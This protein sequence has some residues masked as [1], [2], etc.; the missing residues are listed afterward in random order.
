MSLDIVFIVGCVIFA[1]TVYGTVMAGGTLLT[2]RQLE[3]SPS[4]KKS[5]MVA[6]R[7][8]S[9]N[10]QQSGLTPSPDTRDSFD[11]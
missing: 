4:R 8:V 1:I 7:P 10:Q 11:D 6:V 2:S 5:P 3:N 9:D